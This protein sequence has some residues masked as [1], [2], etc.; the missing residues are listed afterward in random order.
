MSA[1]ICNQY[2]INVML[3]GLPERTQKHIF[4][5]EK[6]YEFSK[7]EDMQEL[8]QI[9]VNENYRSVNHRYNEENTPEIFVFQRNLKRYF[10]PVEVLKAVH[11]Y[12]YQSC[13][14]D[15]WEN[16]IAADLCDAITSRVSS[17]LPGYEDAAWEIQVPQQ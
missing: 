15:D 8:G 9:L 6:T 17:R 16:S 12:Q 14:T 4:L 1:F 5:N 13:E 2:H 11:C 10:K 7:V 3:S